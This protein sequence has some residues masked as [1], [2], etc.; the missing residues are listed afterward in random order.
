MSSRVLPRPVLLAAPLLA[1]LTPLAAPGQWSAAQQP[2]GTPTTVV[3]AGSLQ[4]EA[5]CAGD[6]D[7]ACAATGL[8]FD[9]DDQI[10][11]ETFFALP[12]G[13][14]EYL[15]ALNGS[16]TESY[17][18]GGV[19]GGPNIA[20]ALAAPA[21]VKFYYSDLTHW[22]TDSVNS[23]I[24][25]VPGSFQSELGCTGDWQPDCLRSWLQDLDGDGIYHL[26]RRNVLAGSY[27]CRVAISESW[28]ENYGLGGVPG[29]A[30]I[31]FVQPWSD[32]QLDFDYD[33]ASHILTVTSA[34]FADG[35]ESRGLAAWS[36]ATP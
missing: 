29:G 16:W 30:N 2:E 36:A 3:I 5:G 12:A 33:S 27:E 20:L 24:A 35:F 10:W 4:S 1:L 14:Y 32:Y 6:W 15:G 17:G 31:P 34:L 28:T 9:T 18:Q 23:V 19:L 22:V 25:T 26:T 13:S 7:P 11:Q 21:A 8:A